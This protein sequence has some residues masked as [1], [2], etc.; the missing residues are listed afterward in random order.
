M[1]QPI[2]VRYETVLII[3]HRQLA[4]HGGLDG[5]RDAG[6]LQSTL[7]RPQNLWAYS[8]EKPGLPE[9]AASCAYA[10]TKNHPF[11]DGNKRTAF[12]VC[13]TILNLNGMLLG[14]TPEDR[15]ITFLK[16]AEGALSEAELAEWIRGHLSSG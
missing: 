10:I 13:E 8:E 12:V 9:L 7:M 2:W 5:L 4:E 14:A 6:L 3:H 16:L 1:T 11:L 15:Y